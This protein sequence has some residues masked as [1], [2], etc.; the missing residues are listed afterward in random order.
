M[1]KYQNYISLG[2]FCATASELER[3]GL[4]NVSSP[5]DWCISNFEGVIN[6][7]NDGFDKYL[8]YDLLLQS[9]SCN[10]HYYNKK[11]RTW[12][13]HDFDKYHSL[14]DQLPAVKAKY[15]RRI[16]RFYCNIEQPTL[17]VRY[18]SDEVKDEYDKSEEL[19]W[20]ENNNSQIV[21]LLKSFNVDNDIVYIA[22][23]EVVSSKISIFN[24]EKDENDGVAR[25]PLDKNLELHHIFECFEYDKRQDNLKNIEKKRDK[26]I[27]Y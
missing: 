5:F 22:N 4:R 21:S 7:I 10:A 27:T 8:D 14:A 3:V 12:F 20:I 18:I 26:K 25:K 11:Y 13:Y 16:N 1:K 17:F 19:T 2:Y 6:A 24:V 23:N 15:I 9:D